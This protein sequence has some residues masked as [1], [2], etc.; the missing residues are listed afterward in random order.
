MARAKKKATQYNLGGTL[1]GVVGGALGTAIAPGIG[2]VAGKAIGSALGSGMQ[3]KLKPQVQETVLNPYNSTYAQGGQLTQYN[4][5][6]HEQGGIALGNTGNEVEDGETRK[7]D[8]IFSDR[9]KNKKGKTFADV[10]KGI[11]KKHSKRNGDK[12]SKAAKEKELENLQTEQ[13]TLRQGMVTR[14]IEKAYGG[15]LNEL[16]QN[17]NLIDDV[18]VQASTATTDT[19]PAITQNSAASAIGSR[20]SEVYGLR[21][22]SPPVQPV[23]NA[24]TG[25]G[26]DVPNAA[27]FGAT[28]L[29]NIYDIGR[30]LKGGSP[31]NI[32]R[33]QAVQ[34]E[35]LNPDRAIQLQ[36][37]A[38]LGANELYRQQG[39]QGSP[40]GCFE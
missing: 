17:T 6:T 37:E 13:E 8:Y 26:I 30:G 19:I 20:A 22:S 23:G 18:N 14:A 25:Q 29:G 27:K 2:T 7:E 38:G 1:G 39:G 15:S 36:Q 28:Q 35:E 40:N 32:D 9:L 33:V 34:Y 4:G 3:N 12:L 11:D 16:A 31:V 10:S 24:L 5:N 21:T